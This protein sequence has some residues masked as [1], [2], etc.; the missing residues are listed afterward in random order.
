[1]RAKNF[2]FIYDKDPEGKHFDK[3]GRSEFVPEKRDANGNIIREAQTII[4]IFNDADRST[5][6]HELGHVFLKD[7][8]D[9]FASGKLKGVAKQDWNTLIKWLGVSDIDFNST[10][11]EQERQRWTDAH[12]KFATGFEKYLMTGQ[13]PTAKLK[14]AF[15][16]FKRWLTNIYHSIRNIT[17]TGTDGQQHSF[18][19]SDEIKQVMD[20][21]LDD[22]IH[23]NNNYADNQGQ[24]DFD[25]A[26]GFNQSKRDNTF[27]DPDTVE[28]YN[29]RTFYAT[30]TPLQ[31]NTIDL[32]NVDTEGNIAWGIHTTQSKY[33]AAKGRTQNLDMDKKGRVHLIND[34]GEDVY[35][36]MRNMP[37]GLERQALSAVIDD[38]MKQVTPDTGFDDLSK[39]KAALRE[40]YKKRGNPRE[41][42]H[43]VH[44]LN[45]IKRLK[46]DKKYNGNVYALDTPEDS[47]LLDWDAPIEEQTPEIQRAVRD[48][49]GQLDVMGIQLY[50]K[51]QPGKKQLDL[52]SQNEAEVITGEKFYRALEKAMRSLV[53]DKIMKSQKFGIIN[54]PRMAASIFLHRFGIPGVRFRQKFPKG[55]DFIQHYILWD[56][57]LIRVIGVSKNSDD[58]A[59]APY[60]KNLP[61]EPEQ[62]K[63]QRKAPVTLIGRKAGEDIN[64]ARAVDVDMDTESYNQ[65]IG[66]KGAK[67][68]DEAEG[69]T[70]RMDNLNIAKQMEQKGLPTQNIWYATN[71]M[72]GTEGK[73]RYEILDGEI[74][75][76]NLQDLA[77][78]EIDAGEE[79]TEGENATYHLPDVFEH[80]ELYKAY[81]EL[82]KMPVYTYDTT[83]QEDKS[84]PPAAYDPNDK[85]IVFDKW[86]IMHNSEFSTRHTRY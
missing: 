74:N 84:I 86:T 33:E 77:S 35:E 34:K 58:E 68:L 75:L 31:D 11:S 59:T 78:A 48:I 67:A 2:K 15:E 65:I 8:R 27:V 17:Y 64:Y 28:N 16:A 55:R 56:E 63:P 37:Q 7:L 36:N 9:L 46:K 30:G 3:R 25:K 72:R 54:D 38:L 73:W 20:R 70:T 71:W 24:L 60:R 1:M 21:M 66:E 76:K 43:L 51:N 53:S 5:I 13:A 52:F 62:P 44:A 57:D 10:L 6:L 50:P 49:E 83:S 82:K 80:P 79:A 4:R 14:R 19:L 42:G 22:S 39:I 81:P 26:E 45:S 23:D 61:Q 32:K 40:K 12:E 18:T 29:Q 47:L 41:V 69:V 85:Y